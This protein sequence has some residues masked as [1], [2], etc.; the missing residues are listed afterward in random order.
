MSLYQL[1]FIILTVFALSV[2]QIL[3]KFAAG[4]FEFSVTGIIKNLTNI[5]LIIALAVY[6]LATIMWL[7]VLKSTPLRVAYPF[8]ALAF[9]V[10]PILSHFLIGERIYWNTF[11]GATMFVDTH[12][13]ACCQPPT[14]H[15]LYQG[16]PQI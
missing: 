4:S 14:G 9:I 16:H 11:A 1:V 15:F 13:F 6:F 5:N 8:I 12:Q 7:F 2:G 3:F 10:V